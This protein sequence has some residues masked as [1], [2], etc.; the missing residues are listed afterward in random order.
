MQRRSELRLRIPSLW[1]AQQSPTRTIHCHRPGGG[2][3]AEE[4]PG[5]G[6][7]PASGETA[8]G[9]QAER[10]STQ[11]SEGPVAGSVAGPVAKVGLAAG[12]AARPRAEVGPVSG[13]PIK[14][15]AGVRLEPREMSRRVASQTV[16]RRNSINP[17]PGRES[18]VRGRLIIEVIRPR[19]R[20]GRKRVKMGPRPRHSHWVDKERGKLKEL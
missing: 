12:Q 7:G 19:R 14:R 6:V 3:E 16:R 10:P 4:A 11:L 8:E 5:P 2:V 15:G 9:R 18:E 20:R 13:A 1:D 17:L